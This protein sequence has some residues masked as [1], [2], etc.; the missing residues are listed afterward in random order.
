MCMLYL[1]VVELPAYAQLQ[2]F[3]LALCM[4]FKKQVWLYWPLR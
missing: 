3:S 2:V 1:F 4:N